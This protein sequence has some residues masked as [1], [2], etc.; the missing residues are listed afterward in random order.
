MYGVRDNGTSV[1]TDL[2]TVELAPITDKG[3][4]FRLGH[5]LE[6]DLANRFYRG[7]VQAVRYRLELELDREREGFAFRPDAA[8]TRVGLG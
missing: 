3:R 7:G 2:G 1:A 6:N 4:P 8:V 5:I